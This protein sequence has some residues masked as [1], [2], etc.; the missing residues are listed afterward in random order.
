MIDLPAMPHEQ[1]ASWLGLLDLHERLAE[2]WTLIG[3]QLV[4]LHWLSGG[5]S[6]CAPRTTQTR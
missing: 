5:S 1:T 3:G 4:H 6:R 2:G